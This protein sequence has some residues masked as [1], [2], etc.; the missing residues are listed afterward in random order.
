MA[1]LCVWLW[2][3]IKRRLVVT[4][5]WLCVGPKILPTCANW[6]PVLGN[7]EQAYQDVLPKLNICGGTLAVDEVIKSVPTIVPPGR[8]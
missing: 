1:E 5:Q 4:A 8:L 6:Q 2:A 3:N 7:M